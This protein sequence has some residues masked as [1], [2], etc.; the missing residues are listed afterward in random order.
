MTPEEI[1]NEMRKLKIPWFIGFAEKFWFKVGRYMFVVIFLAIV[2]VGIAAN[3][4]SIQ[5]V[6]AM[7]NVLYI[8]MSVIGGLG[9]LMLA[10]HLIEKRFVNKQANRLGITAHQWNVYAKE[11]GLVSY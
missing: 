6:D 2:G 3:N 7:W 10:S 11:I 1:K 9:L 4:V 8:L 5:Y